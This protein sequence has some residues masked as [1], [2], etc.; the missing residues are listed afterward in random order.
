MAA[1]FWHRQFFVLGNIAC[2]IF[3]QQLAAGFREEFTLNLYKPKIFESSSLL[4]PSD[5][6]SSVKALFL[7]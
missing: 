5:I 4:Q 7:Q 6:K 3:F 1:E 2:L